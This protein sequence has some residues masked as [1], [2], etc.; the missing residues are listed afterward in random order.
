MKRIIM[1]AALLAT[2]GPACADPILLKPLVDLR[3]RYEHDVQD[4]L[5]D[6]STALT[7][8][9][10][11]GVSATSGSLS[12]LVEAQGTTVTVRLPQAADTLATS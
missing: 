5:P 12:A 6:K 7:A 1:A 2:A 10:R 9:L 3:V 8:R 4:G 11:A